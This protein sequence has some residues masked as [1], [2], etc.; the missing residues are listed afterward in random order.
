MVRMIVSCR[1][2]GSDKF[3][4]E[5]CTACNDWTDEQ[6]ALHDAQGA[7]AAGRIDIVELERRIEV[8]LTNPPRR[9][10]PSFRFA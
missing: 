5:R 6:W 3:A 1:N 2:C 10:H 7:Y 8:A 4:H 9:A